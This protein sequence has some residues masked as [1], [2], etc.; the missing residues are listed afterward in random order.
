MVLFLMLLR[1]LL[2]VLCLS[3][4][5]GKKRRLKP[6]PSGSLCGPILGRLQCFVFA[7]RKVKHRRVPGVRRRGLLQKWH[8]HSFLCHL[9]SVDLEGGGASARATAR[10]RQDALLSLANQVASITH[11]VKQMQSN[12]GVTRRKPKKKPKVSSGDYSHGRPLYNGLWKAFEQW[13]AAGQVPSENQIP[14]QLQEV[15]KANPEQANSPLAAEQPR[16]RQGRHKPTRPTPLRLCAQPWTAPVV[17]AN[18]VQNQQ[19]NSDIPFYCQTVA[20]RDSAKKWLNARG[21]DKKH[22]RHF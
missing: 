16:P 19:L 8:Q 3:T 18:S 15:L 20:E 1:C 10:K 22:L 4:V 5:A 14:K 11:Q 21:F 12:V 6:Q 2:R 13:E 7:A 17:S 9:E